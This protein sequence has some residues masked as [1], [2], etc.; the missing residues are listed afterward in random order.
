MRHRNCTYRTSSLYLIKTPSKPCLKIR[1]PTFFFF[2]NTSSTHVQSFK[3]ITS[4]AYL[5]MTP[6]AH[7][8]G[9]HEQNGLM[10]GWPQK[11]HLQPHRPKLLWTSALWSPT[12]LDDVSQFSCDRADDCF[13]GGGGKGQD[14]CQTTIIRPLKALNGLSSHYF[15]EKSSFVTLGKKRLSVFPS[16]QKKCRTTPLTEH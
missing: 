10:F 15:V 6:S 5:V 9:V 2:C 13:F 14:G 7:S 4:S 3:T 16:H 8:T 12:R 11:V 1:S